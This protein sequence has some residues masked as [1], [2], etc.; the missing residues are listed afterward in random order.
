MLKSCNDLNLGEDARC[1]CMNPLLSRSISNFSS[2]F[3][4][5]LIGSTTTIVLIATMDCF[6]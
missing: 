3:V 6:Q 1:P 4:T 2:Y 5:C